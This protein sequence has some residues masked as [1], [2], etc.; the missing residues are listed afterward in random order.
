MH[1][2]RNATNLSKMCV[3]WNISGRKISN[4]T[5]SY[6]C[7][8]RNE[9]RRFQS[10]I[11]HN[12]TTCEGAISLVFQGRRTQDTNVV[13]RFEGSGH[14]FLDSAVQNT[15]MTKT[16]VFDILHDIEKILIYKKLQ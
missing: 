7:N 3:L 13:Y 10:Q 6:I 5:K 16:E 4:A 14:Q 9:L 12:T 2:I 11:V 8:K 1:K 15:D